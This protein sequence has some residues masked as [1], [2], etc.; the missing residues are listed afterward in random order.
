MFA[1]FKQVSKDLTMV[2]HGV[3]GLPPEV[4]YKMILLIYNNLQLITK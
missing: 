4:N 1:K 3:N 2:Y